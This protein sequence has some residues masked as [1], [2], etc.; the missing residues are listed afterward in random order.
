M[1]VN[2]TRE[3]SSHRLN[4]RAH[5]K[6]FGADRTGQLPNGRQSGSNP[7]HPSR[8][9][10]AAILQLFARRFKLPIPLRLNFLLMPRE[11]VLWRDVAHERNP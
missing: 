4:Q 9:P 1:S 5:E 11:H 8:G 7:F 2:G 6:H 3:C 10:L